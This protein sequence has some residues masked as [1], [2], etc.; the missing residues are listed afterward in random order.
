MLYSTLA[1]VVNGIVAIYF[2]ISWVV[3]A[4]GRY[5]FATSHGCKPPFKIP[6]PER[7][8]GWHVFK[9]QLENAKR[10]HVLFSNMERHREFGNSFQ[11]AIFG[12]RFLS[13]IEPENVKAVLATNFK[14][15]ELGGRIKSFGPLLGAGIFTTDGAHWEHSRALVRP[16]FT[17]SQ[18]AD[19]GAFEI[20]IQ[21]VID[22]IPRDGSTVDLQKLFYLLTFDSATE[23]L[24]GESANIL[25]SP[26]GSEQQLFATAFDYAQS[27]LRTRSRLGPFMF[28]YRNK[29]FDRACKRVHNFVDR[30][31]YKAIEFRRALDAGEKPSEQKGKE[32]YVFLNELAK[33]T[34]DPVQLRSELL[35]ILVAGRDTTAGLLANIFHTLVRRPDVWNKLMLEVDE[36][37]GAKPDYDTIKDMKY[38]RYV[39]N[40]SLRLFPSV[41]GNGRVANKHTTIPVGGGPDGLSPVFIP[42]GTLVAYQVFSMHR[43]KDIYGEDADEFRPERWETLRVSWEYLPFN[44]GPRICVGQQFALAEASYTIIRLMQE[45]K[46]IENRD[47]RPWKEG[48]TITLSSGNGVQVAMIPRD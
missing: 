14:D 3:D 6:Q 8:I 9:R 48:L 39:L 41:P 11:V 24:F 2:I 34:R 35:N 47:E 22:K 31:V 44:G 27:Q 4:I 12:Q 20:H 5:R 45:F 13:T 33:A 42:K 21:R 37:H 23:F 7:I 10:G 15:F 30:Y 43:R 32:Q 28:L 29:E 19:L 18:V 38:L 40:E 25:T 17:R 16:S 36:L 46:G 1:L 26:D